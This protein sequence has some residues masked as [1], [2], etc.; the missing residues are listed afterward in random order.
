MPPAGLPH[1]CS[2]PPAL[3]EQ[4]RCRQTGPQTCPNRAAPA[5]GSALKL[6]G[7]PQ[8]HAPGP[9]WARWPRPPCH[10]QTDGPSGHCRH[11]PTISSLC[12]VWVR[13]R[14]LPDL[15]MSQTLSPRA[16]GEKQRPEEVK[17]HGQGHSPEPRVSLLSPSV[18]PPQSRLRPGLRPSVQQGGTSGLRPPLTR[19]TQGHSAPRA[20]DQQ[21]K[22]PRGRPRAPLPPCPRLQLHASEG[23]GSDGSSPTVLWLGYQAPEEGTFPRPTSTSPVTRTP[24]RGSASQTK[25]GAQ[26]H[27]AW[28]EFTTSRVSQRDMCGTRAQHKPPDQRAP[29]PLPLRQPARPSPR[30]PPQGCL[31]RSPHPARGAPGPHAQAEALPVGLPTE[32]SAGTSVTRPSLCPTS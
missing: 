9:A 19:P 8:G 27:P 4:T 26:S 21:S 28:R 6:S 23:L 1:L 30:S 3:E 13:P 18:R 22:Q 14:H 10:T 29:S 16:A 20:A 24:S 31:A 7:T 12:P 5:T 25:A 15:A 2:S 17:G 32:S 11:V